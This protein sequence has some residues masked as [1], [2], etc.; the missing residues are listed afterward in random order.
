MTGQL[1]LRRSW[2]WALAICAAAAIGEGLF[3]GSGVGARFAELALPPYSPPLPVWAIIGALYYLLFFFL[4]KS[5]LGTRPTPKLTPFALALVALLLCANAVWNWFFFRE[6]DLWLSTVFYLPYGAAA[7]TLA[8]VLFRLRSPL[9]FWYLLYV[10]YLAYAG[11][12]GIGLWRL[13]AD[14]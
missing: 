1:P 14:A 11:W 5:L 6:K 10:V 7:V 13:N 8:V 4:L 3:A 2:L 12:W 9:S